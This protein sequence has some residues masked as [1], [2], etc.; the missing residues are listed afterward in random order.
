MNGVIEFTVFASVDGGEM[1]EMTTTQDLSLI[2][3]GVEPGRTYTFTVIAKLGELESPPATTSLQIEEVVEEIPEWEDDG[4]DFEN[5]DD[6]NWNGEN[7][8]NGNNNNG[9]NGNNNNGNGNNGNNGNKVIM[10]QR[11]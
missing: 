3:P 4:T 8:N 1:Q 2:F 7:D 9:N 11:Q 10:E 6:G 5:P